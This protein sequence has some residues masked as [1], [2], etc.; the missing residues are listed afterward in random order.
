MMLIQLFQK[1]L[2]FGR[3]PLVLSVVVISVVFTT[4]GTAILTFERCSQLEN[5]LDALMCSTSSSNL[6]TE[7]LGKSGSLNPKLSNSDMGL[8]QSRISAK[9]A[10]SIAFP[11][12]IPDWK[13]HSRTIDSEQVPDLTTRLSPQMGTE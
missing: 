7:W 3:K 5:P 8:V 10:I 9:E 12:G 2:T 11:T 6:L 13:S 1:L 4:I